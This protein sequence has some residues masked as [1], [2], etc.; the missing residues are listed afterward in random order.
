MRRRAAEAGRGWRRAALP[1]LAGLGAAAMVGAAIAF[2]VGF[3]TTV[4]T[5][6]LVNQPEPIDANNS[7]TVARNPR[8][9]DNLVVVHRVDRPAFSALLEATVDGGRTWAS[10]PL[11][12]PSG[13]DRPFAP[14]AAFAPDGTL[15]VLY[16]NLEGT[17]NTPANLWLARSS[18]GGRTLSAPVRVAGKLAFQPRLALDRRG[19]VYLVWLQ[20]STVGQ[21][22]LGVEPG[23]IVASRSDDGGRTFSEPLTVSDRQRQRVGAASPVVDS[24]GRL[25]VLYEDFKGDR[26]DFENLDGPPSREPFA[27]VVTRS[28]DG[29]RTFSPGVEVEPA[30][31]PTQR[32]VAFLPP[33]P[34]IAAGPSDSLYVAWAD[35]R[36]GDADV[37]LRRSPDGGATWTAPVRVNDNRRGDGTSQDLPRVAVSS[38]GRVDVLFLDRRR[39]PAN[40][41]ADAFLASSRDQGR[42]FSNLRLSSRSF[43]S[44]IGNGTPHGDADLGS[45]LGLDSRDGRTF[46]VWTDTRVGT[47]DTGRQDIAGATVRRLP[48]WPV[49]LW[50]IVAGL[51]AGAALSILLAARAKVRPRSSA[52]LQQGVAE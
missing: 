17:A 15:F 43:D 3:G 45:R 13:A 47:R 37:L 30:V 10:L 27:L 8:H 18:D 41:R 12:L 4:G 31:T 29:A 9:P 7:P 11:P 19:T 42:S 49:A 6:V 38:S 5:N 35:D 16:A 39:D 22:S 36:F 2:F 46:A 44:R 14:D 48:T 33:Y 51:T 24:A 21:F 23:P 28:N 40:V 34:S 52:L 25:E 50:P 20:A 32:F 1:V 26:R